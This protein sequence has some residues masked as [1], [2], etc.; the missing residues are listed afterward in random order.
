MSVTASGG[1]DITAKAYQGNS[2]VA[3]YQY[4]KNSTEIAVSEFE[5]DYARSGSI[6]ITVSSSVA[7]DDKISVIGKIYCYGAK[8]N[9]GIASCKQGQTNYLSNIS[10]QGTAASCQ[11]ESVANETSYLLYNCK[12]TPPATSSRVA[13]STS[14]SGFSVSPS[15]T[16]SLAYPAGTTSPVT[17]GCFNV[18]SNNITATLPTN[19]P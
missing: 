4:S 3:A 15:T 10:I 9:G 14:A 2:S 7:N 19:C 17:G 16:I 5:R 13:V 18:Y 6:N 8:N 12:V 11:L 1:V